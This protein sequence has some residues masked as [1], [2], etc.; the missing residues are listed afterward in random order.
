MGERNVQ[1]AKVSPAISPPLWMPFRCIALICRRPGA[2]PTT[3]GVNPT[4]SYFTTPA[5]YCGCTS[6][7]RFLSVLQ[8]ATHGVVNFYSADVVMYSR[9]YICRTD[10]RIKLFTN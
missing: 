6:L 5:L 4:T 1:V 3:S 10:S 7:Y 9:S 2:N 8:N